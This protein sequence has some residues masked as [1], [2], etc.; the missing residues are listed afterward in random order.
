MLTAM[1]GAT[2]GIIAKTFLVLLAG[3][4]AVWGVADVF[5]GSRDQ[6]LA[7]VGEREISAVEFRNFFDQRLQDLSRRTGQPITAAQA[8]KFGMDR[9]ILGD[10]LRSGALDEQAKTMKMSL[11]G[12]FIAEQIAKNPAYQDASGNFSASAL[13][14][15]LYN[16]SVTEAQFIANERNNMIR[17]AITSA[18]S[19]GLEAPATLVRLVAEQASELRDAAYFT[20]SGDGIE[21]AEPTDKQA[22]EFYIK[23]KSRFAVPERRVFE[24]MS[25]NAATLGKS[26][27]INDEILKTIY[28]KE[29]SRF[30]SP[31]T[32]I[33]EQ[34]PFGNKVEASAALKRIRE[35]VSF[36]SIAKERGLTDK[37]K[38]LGTFKRP[39]VPDRQ[40]AD[41]AFSLK[42]GAVSEPVSGKLSTFLIRVAKITP[43][44]VKTLS[45]VRDE[46]VKI[47]QTEAGRDEILNLRDKVEDERGGGA[48]F[49]EIAKSLGLSYNITPALNRAGFD[50]D[51]KP[52]SDIADWAKVL[53]AGNESDVGLEIDPVATQDDG[54]VWVNIQDVI[55]SHTKPLKE[56]KDEAG[57]MWKAD[58]LRQAIKKKA[59]DLKKRAN[60]GDKFQDLAQQAG[61]EIKK[62]LGFNRRTASANFDSNAVRA[63]FAGKLD[64]V[65]IS[66]NPDGKAAKIMSITPVLA[67]PYNP[68]S[69]EV[70]E[71]RS[72][73]KALINN[74]VYAGYMAELQKSV[75][76][77]IRQDAWSRVFQTP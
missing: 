24:T 23:N 21:I 66:I 16:A 28:E 30:G 69:A 4:F 41:A 3:S 56:A 11:S 75:G 34:I 67:P 74:D 14:Q 64:Q 77:E 27:E 71:I 7:K 65:T 25:I 35:G 63:A 73:L 29:K 1:R 9:Q 51:G 37:D 53:Q 62:E 12:K 76:V 59:E 26:A 49:K 47:I 68:S 36:D 13:Q 18:I 52:G 17:T 70:K 10:L 58:Q 5:T 57:K 42:E 20:I 22:A 55:Q 38:L 6:V 72:Q 15:R 39:D 2:G 32:R 33:I 40:I 43:E 19:D 50:K 60:G 44:N 45:D 8:R 54:F 61:A 48:P 46:L 31:E